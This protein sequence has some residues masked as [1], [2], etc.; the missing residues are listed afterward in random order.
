MGLK[1]GKLG[2]KKYLSI[3]EMKLGLRLEA[4]KRLSICNFEKI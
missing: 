4:W 1:A 2:R 3:G